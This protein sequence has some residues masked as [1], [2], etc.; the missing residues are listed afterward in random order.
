MNT[1][2]PSKIFGLTSASENMKSKSRGRS[3]QSAVQKKVELKDASTQTLRY[4]DYIPLPIII[5]V[6]SEQESSDEEWCGPNSHEESEEHVLDSLKVEVEETNYFAEMYPNHETFAEPHSVP[7]P[8]EQVYFEEKV[9]VDTLMPLIKYKN[10]EPPTETP[11]TPQKAAKKRKPKENANAPKAKRP[12]KQRDN[13]QN[14]KSTPA[15]KKLVECSLCNF[16]CK[17]PSHLKRHMLTHTGERPHQCEF[18]P[19]KFAQKTDLNRHMSCHAVHYDF[20]CN[21]CGRGFPNEAASKKHESNCKTKRYSC[22][23]CNHTTFSIGN[24][25]LHMRKHT[26]E[27]PYRCDVCDKRFT[28]VSHLNQHVKLHAE[29]FD[30]HCKNCGRGFVHADEVEKHQITCKNRQFQ[31]HIC[32]DVHHRMDNLKRH[33]KITHMGEKEVMCEF[34]SKQFPAKSSLTKHIQHH[35]PERM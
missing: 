23:Q 27:R 26:G 14:A 9:N 33:I 20:H 29:D 7:P 28:R 4:V 19:K 11:A 16:V 30:L 31:C 8:V 35:H 3:K 6:K 15:P 17:R 22:D 5:D 25:Q 13:N 1:I 34:C 21:S 10:H 24:L 18:C 2:K 12:K 32:H